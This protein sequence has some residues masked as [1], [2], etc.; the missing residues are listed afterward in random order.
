MSDLYSYKS[1]F[2]PNTEITVIFKENPNYFE[3]SKYFDVYG[4]GFYFPEFKTIFIDGEIFLGEDGLTIDDLKFIEAHEVTHL[5]LNHKNKRSKN[6]E[7]EADLGAY[8]LLKNK[9]LST[10]RLIDEF[11]YRHNKSFSESLLD[12]IKYKFPYKLS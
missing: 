4:Y 10:D 12:I 6:D 7:L 11:E 2:L 8:I 3:L 1:I 5:I 9:N